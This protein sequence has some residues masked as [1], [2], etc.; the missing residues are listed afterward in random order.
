[1]QSARTP[2]E[3]RAITH[4][5]KELVGQRH[6]EL[7]RV[8]SI[9]G[10]VAVVSPVLVAGALYVGLRQLLEPGLLGPVV[11]AAAGLD[12]VVMVWIWRRAG[13]Q[14]EAVQHDLVMGIVEEH[15]IPGILSARELSLGRRPLDPVSL[16]RACGAFVEGTE[17]GLKGG[18]APTEAFRLL[19][20]LG[21]IRVAILPGSRIVVRLERAE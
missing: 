17:R 18:V 7:A 2:V 20:D 11:T 16:R 6:A 13:R 1:M 12:A 15:V 3:T 21:P 10:P 4:D 14:A 8:R 19:A 5:E 9:L